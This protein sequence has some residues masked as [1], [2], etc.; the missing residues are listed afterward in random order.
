MTFL[1]HNAVA[2]DHSIY[3]HV[4]CESAVE[5][6]FARAMDN[7]K[8]VKF[9]FKIP[10][11]FKI[12]T[13]IGSYNPDWAVYYEDLCGKKKLYLV[14]ESKGTTDEQH[15]KAVENFK[16]RCAKKHFAAYRYRYNISSCIRLARSKQMVTRPK[17]KTEKETRC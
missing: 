9:F 8:D 10:K 7:D 11:R 1:D 3:D 13:P 4:V 17:S 6:K 2:V 12:N 14:I 16:N 5:N 15:L